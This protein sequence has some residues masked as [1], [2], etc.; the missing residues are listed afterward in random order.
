MQTLSQETQPIITKRNQNSKNEVKPLKRRN[1]N[2]VI[3]P[4]NV[5]YFRETSEAQVLNINS[6]IPEILQDFHHVE[7]FSEVGKNVLKY[8]KLFKNLASRLIFMTILLLIPV[9]AKKYENLSW[10]TILTR[11]Q[12]KKQQKEAENLNRNKNHGKLNTNL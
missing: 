7:S 5:D 11:D 6:K 4:E 12:K 1:L 8:K 9:F 3:E 2:P 10:E